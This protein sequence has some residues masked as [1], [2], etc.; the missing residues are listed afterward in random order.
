[1]TD[2]LYFYKLLALP[3]NPQP[4]SIYLINTGNDTYNMYVTDRNGV[5]TDQRTKVVPISRNELSNLAITNSLV[6][7]ELWY[8]EDEGRLAVPTS[9]NK[10]NVF[11]A[12]HIGNTPP[13]D[14]SVIWFDTGV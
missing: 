3:D 4:N 10:F 9:E 14:T 7:G 8:I 5:V 12:V 11:F 6:K 13:E 2:K 1:M